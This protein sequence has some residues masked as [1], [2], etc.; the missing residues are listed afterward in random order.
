MKPTEE[1]KAEHQGILVALRILDKFASQLEAGQEVNLDHLDQMLDF[2]RTFADRCHHGKEEDLLFVEMVKAGVPKERGPIGVMLAEHVQGRTYV[3][4]MVEALAAYRAGDASARKAIVANGRGYVDL[5]EQHIAK[6]DD[7][8]YP[9]ADACLTDEQQTE[10]S[11]GFER[12]EQERIGPG[13][14]EAFHA[15]LGR[16]EKIYLS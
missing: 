7:I 15:M 1:L 14:H 10:L 12:V 2:I 13:R 5:L 4:G 3:R 16:L 8:L 6:E 9:M 11:E